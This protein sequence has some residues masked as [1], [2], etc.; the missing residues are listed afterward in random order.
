[1]FLILYTPVILLKA[2]VVSES[3]FAI[4]ENACGEKGQQNLTLECL[5]FFFLP[6]DEMN[7]SALCSCLLIFSFTLPL[8][9]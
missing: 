9:F 3:F 6:A 8:N 1:M 5:L 4:F 2:I 7:S